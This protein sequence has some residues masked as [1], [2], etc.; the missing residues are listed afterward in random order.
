MKTFKF[1]T[2][3]VLL[4]C[5]SLLFSCN[6]DD[7]DSSDAGD[8]F[9]SAKIDGTSWTSSKDYN[10]TA[11]Q[12][13]GNVLAVQGSDNDGN[14]INFNIANYSGVG[15]Y[16]TG[17]NLTNGSQIMYVSISPVGSW[18]SNLATAALGT[19]IPGTIDITKDDGSVFEGTFSFEGY[20]AS[21]KTIKKFT[22]GKFKAEI[23]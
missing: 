20:N 2:V 19:L 14:A 9:V 17:D 18:S 16:K 12:K 22:E 1:K 23:Q 7:N 4:I 3:S 11:A 6:K 15:N 13:S 21:T 5:L 8:E 10:T